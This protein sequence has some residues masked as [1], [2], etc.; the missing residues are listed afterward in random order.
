MC[1]DK[2]D[3]VV[4]VKVEK[5]R[6]PTG[7]YLLLTGLLLV[8]GVYAYCYKPRLAAEPPEVQ[9]VFG[10]KDMVKD[11]QRAVGAEPD[12]IV[13][14]DTMKKTNEAVKAEDKELFND[15]AKPF[16]TASGGLEKK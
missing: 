3:K 15:Y 7:C 6:T 8:G 14:Y 2:D 1:M 5:S 12:G 4:K 13:G 16:F 11:L 10:I 9:A